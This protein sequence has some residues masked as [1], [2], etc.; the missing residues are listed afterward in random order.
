MQSL[1]EAEGRCLAAQEEA[2]GLKAEIRLHEAN[3]RDSEGLRQV[4][5]QQA[6][7][8]ISPSV[9]EEMFYILAVAFGE[10]HAIYV[11]CLLGFA[12]AGSF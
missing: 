4:C 10:F 3:A 9:W 5:C 11:V 2:R 8:L 6:E 1:A 7:I 12:A